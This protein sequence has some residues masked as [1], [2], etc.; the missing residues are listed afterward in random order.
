MVYGSIK[1]IL[2][3][4]ERI[5]HAIKDTLTLLPTAT[6]KKLLNSAK[7]EEKPIGTYRQKMNKKIK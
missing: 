3:I 6:D 7:E 1:Y 4:K 2:Y 5:I